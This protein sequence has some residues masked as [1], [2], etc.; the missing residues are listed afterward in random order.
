MLAIENGGK[1]FMSAD[2]EAISA[3]QIAKILANDVR[4]GTL[5]VGEM[6]QSER[7]LCK[8]FSVGRNAIRESMTIL[9]AMSFADHSKGKRPR[10]ASPTL[11][12]LMA[13]MSESAQFFFADNE[14]KAH[15]EQARLFLE[16]SMLRYAITNATNAQI[17][18]MIS[19]IQECD[20]NLGDVGA[21]READVKFHRALAEVPGNP[22]F[23]ALHETFVEQL[24]KNRDVPEDFE[25][26]N[27]A[28]NSDHKAIMN[29]LL[30][31]DAD[32]AVEVL[33]FHL[34]RNYGSNFHQVFEQPMETTS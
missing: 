13:G 18:K 16:T 24:M 23:V 19:A 30:A 1:S 6:F 22:I 7:E 20:E 10:V 8:R 32:K 28:S 9:Q 21:F 33:T 14:G 4:N 5:K 2:V 12:R 11:A 25:A 29:A 15:L 17:G 26:R 3:S 27:R 34:I 31:K